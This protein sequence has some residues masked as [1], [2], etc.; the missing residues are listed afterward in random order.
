MKWTRTV[1]LV[2]VTIVVLLTSVDCANKDTTSPSEPTNLLK[3]TPCNDNTPTFTWNAATDDD[4]G[5][6]YY[7]LTIDG[8][9]VGKLWTI[10]GGV[11]TYTLLS[12]FSLSDGNHTFEV[13]AVDK[14]GNEGA[15]ASLNF[16]CDTTPPIISSVSASIP[17]SSMVAVTWTTNEDAICQV[18]YGTTTAYGSSQPASISHPSPY[19]VSFIA[20]L[21]GLSADTTYH[22][23]VRSIDMC[24]N[25]TV[26]G[27][28][29]FVTLSS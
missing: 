13:K 2:L 16:T 27:D 19:A 21:N 5:V 8:G 26:S 20:F 9:V 15:G 10:V 22:Y 23:R 29:S 14:A 17:S 12:A 1:S 7:L 6:D 28:Y 4:S 24:G 18:E 11:A 25:E 3:T